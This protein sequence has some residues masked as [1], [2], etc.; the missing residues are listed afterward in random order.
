V[1]ECPAKTIHLGRYEDKNLEAK[2]LAYTEKEAV[3][4]G[5]VQ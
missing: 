4:P 1:A 5:G 3:S 2:I